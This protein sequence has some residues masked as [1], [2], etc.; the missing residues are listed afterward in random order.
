MNRVR[1][2]ARCHLALGLDWVAPCVERSIDRKSVQ[3]G[4]CDEEER[5]F[6]KMTPGAAPEDGAL[7]LE[8]LMRAESTLHEP[9]AISEDECFRIEHILVELTVFQETLRHE[10]RWVW[11]ILRIARKGPMLPHKYTYRLHV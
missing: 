10:C 3:H 7:R 9:P 2:E 6:R 1:N 4:G 5:V 8:W 11:V